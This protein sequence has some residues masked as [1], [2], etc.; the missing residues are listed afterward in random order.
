MH[1]LQIPWR[2]FLIDGSAAKSTDKLLIRIATDK[3][4]N[5]RPTTF[6]KRQQVFQAN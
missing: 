5:I 1:I 4:P 3:C 2:S 6:K